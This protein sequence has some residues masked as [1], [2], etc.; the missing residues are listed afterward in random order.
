MA[1]NIPLPSAPDVALSKAFTQGTDLYNML[2]QHAIQRAQNKRLEEMQPYNI[3]NIESQIANRAAVNARQQ[4]LLNP[5]LQQYA[6]L[7]KKFLM[8]SDPNYK[9]SQLQSL[10]SALGYGGMEG[11]QESE[12]VPTRAEQMPSYIPSI[13]K[14]LSDA[15]E[16]SFIPSINQDKSSLQSIL[17]SIIEAVQ[18]AESDNVPE[19]KPDVIS[20]YDAEQLSKQQKPK[21]ENLRDKVLKGILKKQYGVDLDKESPEEKFQREVK[22]AE[23]KA[24][25]QSQYATRGMTPEQRT[26]QLQL[27]EKEI[28]AKIKHNE[29]LEANSDIDSKIKLA[30]ERSELKKEEARVKAQLEYNKKLNQ[31]EAETFA[32]MQE[33]GIK[34]ISGQPKYNEL[35]S[36]VT[37]PVFESIR[38]HPMFPRLELAALKAKGSKE[39]QELIG[40]FENITNEIVVDMA[41]NMNSRFTNKDLDLAQ[42]MKISEKDNYNS[43]R[44][45][46]ETILFLHELG[47][48]RLEKALQLIEET[49]MSPFNAFK[50]ADALIDG[51][52]IREQIRRDMGLGVKGQVSAKKKPFS[53]DS[54]VR[55]EMDDGSI[56]VMKYS[57]ALKL[58]AK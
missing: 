7:H 17:P 58:G 10:L 24:K 8:E 38:Q 26:K 15:Q 18:R 40:R 2:M 55:V 19:L 44:A 56:K 41:K 45:K 46:A 5:R 33:E 13:R 39:Q 6:D 12:I 3:K 36:I 47:Q 42:Q 32:Q 14:S 23:E 20:E 25:I 30:Q 48:Q 9:A 29:W 22:L 16:Q 34:G 49:R 54:M 21:S 37:D 50:Q 31:K 35:K 43:A 28:E 51:D 57:E 27:K 53:P 52:K 4:A 11:E 1:L